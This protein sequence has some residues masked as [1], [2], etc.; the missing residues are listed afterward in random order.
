MG[1]VH[2]EREH[3]NAAPRLRRS[4]RQGEHRMTDGYVHDDELRTLITDLDDARVALEDEAAL[5]SD[6]QIRFSVREA[7]DLA[8]IL[9]TAAE[10]LVDLREQHN[11]GLDT[12]P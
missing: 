8:N 9:R 7:F 3:R 1:D 4:P 6:G 11:K 10:Y 5:N 12:V 2:G